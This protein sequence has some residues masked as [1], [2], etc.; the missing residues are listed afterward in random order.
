MLKAVC[1]CVCDGEH[2]GL[3]IV[4]FLEELITDAS[5]FIIFLLLNFLNC[6]NKLLIIKI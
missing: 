3:R 2:D 1:V 6:P 5:S 4:E